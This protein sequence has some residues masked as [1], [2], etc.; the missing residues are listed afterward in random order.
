MSSYMD[1]TIK[2]DPSTQ[3]FNPDTGFK[4]EGL[5]PIRMLVPLTLEI[6]MEKKQPILSLHYISRT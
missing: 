6:F 4:R 5:T 3:W 1:S 2:Y